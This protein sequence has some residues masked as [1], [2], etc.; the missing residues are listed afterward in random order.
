MTGDLA[1][2]CLVTGFIAGWLVRSVFVMAEISRMQERMQRKV[3][4]WQRETARARSIAE[5]LARQLAARTGHLSDGHD[6]SQ[7]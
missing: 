4:H 1:M 2:A 6:W 3:S 5:Q 7:E